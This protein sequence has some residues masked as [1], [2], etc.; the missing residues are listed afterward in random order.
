MMMMI[1]LLFLTISET[2]PD[3]S[4]TR[5]PGPWPADLSSDKG[6]A[7]RPMDVGGS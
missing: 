7:K 6:A 3:I 4:G 1:L 2:W 5:K